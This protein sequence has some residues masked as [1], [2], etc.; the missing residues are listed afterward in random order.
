MAENDPD[1][2][3]VYLA[4]QHIFRGSNSQVRKLKAVKGLIEQNKIA[5]ADILREYNVERTSNVAKKLLG[6]QVFD[7][8]LKAKIRFPELFDVSPTQSAEREASE[9]EAARDEA[10]TVQKISQRETTG[11]NEI[12]PRAAHQREADVKS[13]GKLSLS[14]IPI[15]RVLTQSSIFCG[16]KFGNKSYSSIALPSVYTLPWST[17]CPDSYSKT[18]GGRLLRVRSAALSPNLER[19]RL[20]L[21]RGCRAYR[22]D[23]VILSASHTAERKFVEAIR[24]GHQPPS[25]A[26]ALGRPQTSKDCGWSRATCRKCSNFSWSSEWFAPVW[27]SYATPKRNPINNWRA[28]TQQRYLRRQVACATQRNTC[29]KNWA[30]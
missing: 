21:Y 30:G 13:E 28:Q 11:E 6:N 26:E 25:G 15:H 27:K 3:L 20:G 16:P 4:C 12:V 29:Q 24:W 19:T 18:F 9:A 7:S 17:C 5:L 22:M 1:E 2:R 8:T 23:Q 10:N 14:R